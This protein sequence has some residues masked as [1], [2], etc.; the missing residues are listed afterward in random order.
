VRLAL[1]NAALDLFAEK[2]FE[3]TTVDDI[4]ARAEVSKATFFRY[5]AS[6]A[7]VIFGVK[8][9]HL[10]ALKEA[11]V[12]RPDAEPDIVAI[13]HAVLSVWAPLLCPE[14]VARQGRAAA[15]SSMLRGM[16][17]DLGVLW[18]RAIAD[19]LAQR[20]KLDASDQRSWIV[21]GLALS[22]FSN[23]LNCWL[24]RGCPGD[25][26]IAVDNT[27]DVIIDACAE[28]QSAR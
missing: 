12:A 11:I 9:Q 26:Q 5:F 15:S 13:R 25:L 23:A 4:A 27:F 16:S 19:A 24:Y 2:G 8:T 1:E 28:A 14:R 7:D 22:A 3:E 21:A 17:F 6:K 18:Q 20:K 10:E